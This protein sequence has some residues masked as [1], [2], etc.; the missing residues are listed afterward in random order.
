MSEI[1]FL[2]IAGMF[3]LCDDSGSESEQWCWVLLDSDVNTCEASVSDLNTAS[4][5]QEE[6]LKLRF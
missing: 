4:L 3:E 1:F 5:E 6:L 2:G